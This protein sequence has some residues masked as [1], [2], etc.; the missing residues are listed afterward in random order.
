MCRV[1]WLSV[2]LLMGTARIECRLQLHIHSVREPSTAFRVF[3]GYAL[4]QAYKKCLRFQL[5]SPKSTKT[6]CY[7]I[8]FGGSGPDTKPKNHAYRRIWNTGNGPN[9]PV[10]LESIKTPVRKLSSVVVSFCVVFGSGRGTDVA[11][12]PA[13]SR[14]HRTF[15]GERRLS[16]WPCGY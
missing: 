13:G 3:R 12:G 14:W 10:R 16:A 9:A 2:M 7:S 4:S 11:G 8:M 1:Q 6:S 5:H 15:D